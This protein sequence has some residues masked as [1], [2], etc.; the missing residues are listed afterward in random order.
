MPSTIGSR[1]GTDMPSLAADTS[2]RPPLD[3]RAH[4]IMVSANSAAAAPPVT[5]SRSKACARPAC[6]TSGVRI[7]AMASAA[8]VLNSRR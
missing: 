6:W 1:N 8:V 4:A 7:V 3:A 5:A 2:R